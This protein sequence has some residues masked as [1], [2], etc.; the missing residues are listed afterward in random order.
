MVLV[1]SESYY[2][3]TNPI[4]TFA[5]LVPARLQREAAVSGFS[6]LKKDTELSFSLAKSNAFHLQRQQKIKT[7]FQTKE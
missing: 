5:D 7:E 4:Y 3:Y 1:G 2:S 6:V